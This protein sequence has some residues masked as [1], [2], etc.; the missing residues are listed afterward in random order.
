M[1]DIIS[2]KRNAIISEMSRVFKESSDINAAD[3]WM[4]K[5]LDGFVSTV[6][7]KEGEKSSDFLL[8]LERFLNN[9][10]DKGYD[11]DIWIKVMAVVRK[12][13]ISFI[14]C[15]KLS[16]AESL[17]QQ[18]SMLIEEV[19]QREQA[20]R[21][22]KKETKSRIL[23]EIESTLL[24]TF[25]VSILMDILAKQLPRLEIPGFYLALYDD[26]QENGEHGD[27]DRARLVL[28]Y[29]K[30]GFNSEGRMKLDQGGN[31][32]LSRQLLPESFF[33]DHRFSFIIEP[34]NF[35]ESH[36][37]YAIFEVGQLNG[38]IYDSLRGQISSALQGAL[39]IE[40]VQKHAKNL[41]A[42]VAHTL[43]ASEKIQ[44]T[45]SETS[46]QA[47]AVSKTAQLSMEVSKTGND[48]ISC[49]I[50]GMDVIKQQ[51]EGIAGTILTLSKHTKQ[52][53]EIIA[54]MENIVAQSKILSINA[55]IQAAR[56]GDK[57]LGFSVVARE[58]SKLAEQSRDATS[59][60]S[61][62]LNEIYKTTNTAV[63][64]T[65]EGS[66]GV[67]EGMKLASNAGDA[68]HNLTATI[69]EAARLAIE[70]TNRT[71]QQAN[72]IDQLVKAV[73]SIKEASLQTSSSFKDIG[74]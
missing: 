57:G 54:A 71:D 8:T 31:H 9:T 41:D 69:E 51:V 65:K 22:F 36:L 35:Q 45:I 37:G 6:M 34:L 59:K 74:L 18:A 5:I 73:Q 61:Y 30:S 1:I 46:R 27:N 43:S 10:K 56:Y 49:T 3:E 21:I 58:M 7:A 39:L 29:G 40:Q 60:I 2:S 25:S 32:L 4:G 63:E 28:A 14:N 68:I 70:I 66:L 20:Y 12:E 42:I 15:E 24:T 48:A 64:S 52:I 11:L 50:S 67:Q 53:G 44:N 26:L 19:S 16:L 72:A 33:P 13:L 62:I 47:Q 55:S 23:R 38:V 17:C